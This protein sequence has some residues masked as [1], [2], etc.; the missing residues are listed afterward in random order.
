MKRLILVLGISVFSLLATPAEARAS[1]Y[2]YADLSTTIPHKSGG[3]FDGVWNDTH[4]WLVTNGHDLLS[5]NGTSFAVT[6][7]TP[8]LY[9]VGMAGVYHA[10]GM[11]GTWLLYGTSDQAEAAD[12]F[13]YYLDSSCTFFAVMRRGVV[14][15][16]DATAVERRNYQGI[17]VFRAG[18]ALFVFTED[19]DRTVRLY[20]LAGGRL[21]R[22]SI[23]LW[24]EPD[25]FEHLVY[26]GTNALFHRHNNG[27]IWISFTGS[28]WSEVRIPETE[29]DA[30][31]RAFIAARGDSFWGREPSFY[32]NH[33][34]ACTYEMVNP[35]DAIERASRRLDGVTLLTGFAE[36]GLRLVLASPYAHHGIGSVS[37]TVSR[38]PG[39]AGR[40]RLTAHANAPTQYV[41]IL[42]NGVGIAVCRSAHCTTE[43]DVS[44]SADRFEAWAQPVHV[45]SYPVT[46]RAIVL[47]DTA[48]VLETAVWY[49]HANQ[50]RETES[51][52]ETWAD[53]GAFCSEAD[54]R[55]S[56]HV[57]STVSYFVQQVY[58]QWEGDTYRTWFRANADGV[59]RVR[60]AVDTLT[61][62]V[63]VEGERA[64]ACMLSEAAREALKNQIQAQV[65]RRENVSIAIS[66]NDCIASLSRERL[67]SRFDV[68]DPRYAA[69]R[70]DELHLRV[71]AK[72]SW[73]HGDR[74]VV[75]I[76]P[77]D[78][79]RFKE[80]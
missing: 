6:N 70:D 37:L 5:V 78:L 30:Q 40:Y 62:N 56:W 12:P 23:P 38:M 75:A 1:A 24:V 66:I 79:V 80:R 67:M 19:A 4:D 50:P 60:R 21:E 49:P 74:K 72:V 31:R 27:G 65:T 53:P 11:D 55:V 34:L 47:R 18:H 48:S 10:A 71:Y 20:E 46:S 14:S 57:G 77:T 17:Y 64:Y 7:V 16:V 33:E 59:S 28:A 54:G 51:A 13:G 41:R 3:R 69:Y 68:N 45:R 9:R 52:Y 15:R 25:R 39:S 8:A 2:A 22:R 44:G 36:N 43:V 35:R 58:G 29:A 42:K 61:V 73:A 63:Y 26:E 76:S 32:V